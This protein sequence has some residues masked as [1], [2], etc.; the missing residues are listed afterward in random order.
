MLTGPTYN[1]ILFH[2]RQV[3][4]LFPGRSKV[5]NVIKYKEKE[6][7]HTAGETVNINTFNNVENP[8]K[9]ENV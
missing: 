4:F 9:S 2:P 7:L 3:S 8:Q 6:L 1:E 5:T